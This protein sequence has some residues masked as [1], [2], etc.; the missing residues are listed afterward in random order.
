M[1]VIDNGGS[2]FPVT[3]HLNKIPT[4]VDY[5]GSVGGM[6]LRDYF[7]AAA[8]SIAQANWQKHNDENNEGEEPAKSLVAEEAYEYADAML[9]A[10]KEAAS[11]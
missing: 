9:A 2:A 3:Q 6:S 8:L 1:K 7:A 11:E 4:S 10:R 5:I